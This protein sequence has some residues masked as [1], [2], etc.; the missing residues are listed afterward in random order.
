MLDTALGY[1]AL[2][3]S[4]FPLHTPDLGT[5]RCSCG[6]R[7]GK[8]KGPEFCQAKHPRT[9]SGFREASKD[10]AQI[11]SWWTRWPAANIGIATGKASGFFVVDLDEGMKNGVKVDGPARWEELQQAHGSDGS[12]LEIKSG[13][14]GL[15]LAYSYVDG[16]TT[17][18]GSLPDGIDIRGTGG[19]IVAP[20]SL[21]YSGGVYAWISPPSKGMSTPPAWLVD[22]IQTRAAR[23]PEADAVPMN[24]YHTV[25]RKDLEDFI[26]YK[27]RY[28]EAAN[29]VQVAQAV[30][31][32]TSWGPNRYTKMLS[33]IGA[34]RTYIMTR[35]DGASVDPEGS[36]E[37][38]VACTAAAT[39][40]GVDT[41]TDKHWVARLIRNLSANDADY[42]GK[43][44]AARRARAEANALLPEGERRERQVRYPL[45]HSGNAERLVD[46]HG[47]QIRFVPEWKSWLSWNGHVWVKSSDAA[48]V[49]QLMLSTARS[50]LVEADDAEARGHD[51]YAKFMRKWAE[52][53]ESAYVRDASVRLAS[54]DPRVRVS[55]EVLDADNWMLNCKN[56]TIDLLTSGLLPHDQKLLITKSAGVKYD[57]DAKCPTWERFVSDCMDGD[58][59]MVAYLQRWC[60]YMLSGSVQEHALMFNRGEG[61][62]GKGTFFNT[63]LKVWGTYG[64][65][66]ETDMLLKSTGSKHSTGLTDLFRARMSIASET[67]EGRSWDEPLLKRLTGGDS[68]TARRMREDNWTFR[69]THKIAVQA[70]SEPVVRSTDDGVWRRMHAVP[71]TVSFNSRPDRMLESKLEAEL[72]GVLAWCVRGCRAWLQ[73]GLRAPKKVL[74][75]TQAYR[76]SQDTFAQFVNDRCVLEEAAKITRAELRESYAAW[77]LEQGDY[78]M[79]SKQFAVRMRKLGVKEAKVKR[80]GSH[81]H[82]RG[83]EGIRLAKN[84]ADQKKMTLIHGGVK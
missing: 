24:G 2:G 1:A 10:E 26:A 54:T 69:P 39:D 59:E 49:S 23:M 79:Q 57:P 76:N 34:L 48:E 9:G 82:E 73:G 78:V 61:G 38:F 52:D 7:L 64:M 14:G 12:P 20:P 53:S 58:L 37:L 41:I 33:F 44:L 17:S 70:N 16:I 42:Q 40:E 46:M 4:V 8:M 45:T 13:S 19:Y 81:L 47:T 55:F 66:C 6:K 63:L 65:V 60:G 29:Q 75:A 77:C 11:R 50:I 18:S 43:L 68:I 5:G 71:F 72:E 32:G 28:A 15:H 27:E 25:T 36:S 31:N 3:F 22:A 74:D 62:N 84:E 51:E 67:E 83:W 35:Y 30:L 21:H 80:V 56:G